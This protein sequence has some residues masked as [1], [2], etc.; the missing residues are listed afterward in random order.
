M[1]TKKIV[2]NK[3]LNLRG[4]VKVAG[5]KNSTLAILAATICVGEPCIIENVPDI[6]DVSLMCGILSKLGVEISMV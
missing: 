5:A 4:N 1:N 3:S 6:S 2:I